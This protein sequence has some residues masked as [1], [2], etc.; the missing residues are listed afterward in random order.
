MYE[1]LRNNPQYSSNETKR[2]LFQQGLFSLQKRKQKTMQMLITVLY[3]LNL[4][5]NRTGQS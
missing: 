5:S 1:M 2:H 3:S 4:P